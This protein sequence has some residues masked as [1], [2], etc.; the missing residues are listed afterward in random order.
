MMSAL[1]VIEL[2]SIARGVEVA[3]AM[4]KASAIEL[5]E[6]K[7]ICPG[8]YIAII[9]GDVSGV[10]NSLKIGMELAKSFYVDHV[11][12]P[13]VHEEVIYALRGIPR[14][15]EIRA[16]GVLEFFSVTGAIYATDAAV[17]AADVSVVDMRLGFAIGG[18]SYSIIT[19]DVSAISSAMEAGENYGKER[20]LLFNI[21]EIPSPNEELKKKLF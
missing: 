4:A 1:G 16:I 14:A 15:T 5:I 10:E 18:K 6:A 7:S 11:L 13:N 3:D 19:G 21:T 9:A 17:K 20:G 2:N 12:I 8:K